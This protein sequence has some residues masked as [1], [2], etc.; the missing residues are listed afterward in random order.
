MQVRHLRN[1]HR[2][3]PQIVS[4][5]IWNAP[6]PDALMTLMHATNRSHKVCQHTG[7]KMVRVFHV[8]PPGACLQPL[9]A[10]RVQRAQLGGLTAA[11]RLSAEP[12]AMPLQRLHPAGWQP[13]AACGL[14]C[15]VQPHMQAEPL[16]RMQEAYP[17]SPKL[18]N[19]RNWCLVTPVGSQLAP[20]PGARRCAALLSLRLLQLTIV[21]E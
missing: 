15:S 5:A 20:P 4:S 8:S 16:S 21:L 19:R 2:F 6:P 10:G 3:M 17:K 7:E 12:A 11:L 13:A 14:R 9:Q 18:L 1:D